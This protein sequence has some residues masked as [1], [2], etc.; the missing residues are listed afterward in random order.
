MTTGGAYR[1]R[2]M[3]VYAC[4]DLLFASRIGASVRHAGRLAR[5]VRS[6]AMLTARLDRVDDGRANAR[7]TAV[8]I[9]LERD[10]ALELI[11]LAR[12]HAASPPVVAFG[13]HVDVPRLRAAGDA[14]AEAMAR[15]RFVAELEARVAALPPA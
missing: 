12:A 10:D 14:G 8:W 5:P 9:D 3:L 6:E 11:Q 13:P 15:G 7:V 1:L 4:N 2:P